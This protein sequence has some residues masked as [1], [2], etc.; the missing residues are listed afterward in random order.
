METK[1]YEEIADESGWPESLR[2]AHRHEFKMVEFLL[3][4]KEKN[5]ANNL[6]TNFGPEKKLNKPLMRVNKKGQ[7]VIGNFTLLN[8]I[9]FECFNRGIDY[10]REEFENV[11]SSKEIFSGMKEDNRNKLFDF[12]DNRIELIQKELKSLREQPVGPV[13]Y[14]DNYFEAVD[15]LINKGY[16]Q[17]AAFDEVC[18]KYLLNREGFE[19][20]YRAR[21]LN[22]KV[23]QKS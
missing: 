1:T 17:K 23:K 16:K 6:I 5:W 10:I 4:L 12:F 8:I 21:W 9:A 14:K 19:K 13:K 18:R 20:Q 3:K 15:E 2:V 22:R 11:S 7:V